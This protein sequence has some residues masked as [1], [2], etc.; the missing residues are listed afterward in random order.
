[1]SHPIQILAAQR[2]NLAGVL[3]YLRGMQPTTLGASRDPSETS[4][5]A[6]ALRRAE[7]AYT[8]AETEFQ[9]AISTL[10]AAEIAELLG[11]KAA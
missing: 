11:G 1:M 8:V 5:Y 7:A 2:A 4:A 9:R 3:E 6:T 10:T